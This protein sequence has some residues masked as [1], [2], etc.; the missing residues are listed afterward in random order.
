VYVLILVEADYNCPWSSDR[1]DRY[2][3]SSRIAT[4]TDSRPGA[5]VIYECTV[6]ESD[7]EAVDCVYGSNGVSP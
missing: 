3:N 7:E 4:G 6:Y 1:E 5:D 2:V